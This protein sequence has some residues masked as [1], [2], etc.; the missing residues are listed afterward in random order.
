MLL[1]VVTIVLGSFGI[2]FAY[3]DVA[4]EKKTHVIQHY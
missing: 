1:R 2:S 4:F 3:L